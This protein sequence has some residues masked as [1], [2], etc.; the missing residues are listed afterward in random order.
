M[1]LIDALRAR[2]PELSETK[3]YDHPPGGHLFDRQVNPETWEPE[4]TG[5]ERDSWSRVWRFLDWHLN[6]VRGYN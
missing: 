3:V 1:Q 5:E 4:S 2:K 6:H